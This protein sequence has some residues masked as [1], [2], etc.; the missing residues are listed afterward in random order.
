MSLG[1]VV[2]SIKGIKVC[3]DSLSPTI[4]LQLSDTIRS[5]EQ[6]DDVLQQIVDKVLYLCVCLCVGGCGCFFVLSNRCMTNSLSRH[7]GG[8]VSLSK[9]LGW[10][11]FLEQETLLHPAVCMGT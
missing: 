4:Y 10:Y 11:C 5:R 8:I 7:L 6:D 3:G 9:T 1:V 2:Y